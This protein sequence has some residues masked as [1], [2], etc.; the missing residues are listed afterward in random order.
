[1]GATETLLG[2]DPVRQRGER[3]VPEVEGLDVEP[4]LAL[5]ICVNYIDLSLDRGDTS[6]QPD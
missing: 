6:G 2:Q 4:Q 3:P 5:P 1:M